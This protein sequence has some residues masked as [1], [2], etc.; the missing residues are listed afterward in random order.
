MSDIKKWMRIMESVPA[1]FPNQPSPGQVA[2]RDATVMVSPHRGGGT[3]RYMHS[4]PN[5][6]MIDIKGVPVEMAN[7]DWSLPERDYEEP[8]KKGN[9]WFHMSQEPDS[10]GRMNDK[11]EFRPGDMVKIADVYG[12]II[13]PG[14]GVFI[15]YSTTGK[16]C[17]VSFDDKEILVPTSSV[18][19]VLEQDAKNK[20]D[21]LDNDG[22][23]SPMSLGSENVKPGE[24][25]AMDH[26]DEFSKWMQTV[27]EALADE[28]TAKLATV[29]P[30][31]AECGCGAW[32]CPV[33][34]P[35]QEPM[36]AMP[37]DVEVMG[38]EPGCEMGGEVCPM[39][40]HAHEDGGE[41]HEME[42]EMPLEDDGMMGAAG[43]A[44]PSMGPMVDEEPMHFDQEPK[45]LPRGENGG[46]KL[47]HI[48]QKFVPADQDGE[49]SPL[50]HSGPDRAAMEEDN[51]YD[52]SKDDLD[53]DPDWT[54][55]DVG[56]GDHEEERQR[57]AEFGNMSDSDVEG[58]EG[59][60][61]HIMDMQRAGLSKA[62]HMYSE[63]DFQ[64]MGPSELKK[65]YDTV[66]GTVSEDDMPT[67]QPTSV[68]PPS[69]TS[70][71]AGPSSG[72]G[73]PASPGANYSPGTAPTMPESF[74][75]GRIM[76]NVDKDVAA[77]LASLKRYDTLK[78]SVAPVLGM[79]TLGE[80]KG[81]KPEWLIDAE[82]KAEKKEGKS[83]ESDSE[84][85]EIDESEEKNPWEKLASD[86]KEEEP[87]S[88][89]TAK[90]G[91]VTK[92]EKG[93]THKGTYG[94]EKEVKEAVQEQAD[95]DVL[96]WMNRFSKLG[97]MKGYGR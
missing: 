19:A 92:S 48:V 82:K 3:G 41:E 97:N 79:Q 30:P 76:E 84:G 2:K 57:Q 32:D 61:Q 43:A 91:T 65:A 80:K 95:P 6:A 28:A 75:Q 12:T 38:G 27:E 88:H 10:I 4:T 49:E 96:E 51:W 15:A 29:E 67:T 18:G 69:S 25:P 86:K 46:V 73:S 23:L 36:D 14:F 37:A 59:M 90:G 58:A 54:E 33:C 53:M 9:D 74:N 68:A 1:T 17:I 63:E 34:F 94:G 87:K 7:E 16:E 70:M 8:Y 5:G 22:N 39:C 78:E 52:P 13:G 64:N 83:G 55:N 40:G 66:M 31:Q 35:E 56:F 81:G 47:G 26:R 89:K 50:S 45:K 11:P 93:L 24:E 72:G 21:E 62:S 77:M 20:F 60:M 85:G 42:V 44:N 71:G